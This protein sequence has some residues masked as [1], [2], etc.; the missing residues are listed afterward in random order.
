MKL[1]QINTTVNS[2]SIG[3]IARDIG[4][5]VMAAGE[6]S[7]IAAAYTNRPI[8]FVVI[9][10]GNKSYRVLHG[11]KTRLLIGMVLV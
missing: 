3:L 11:L 2:G 8:G 7:Y 5:T 4:L 9:P 1:L 10:I 6:Q